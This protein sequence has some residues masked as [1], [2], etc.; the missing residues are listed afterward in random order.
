M[1]IWNIHLNPYKSNS[2]EQ[3]AF[4]QKDTRQL[5][6]NVIPAVNQEIIGLEKNYVIFL[7]NY[8]IKRQP[9]NAAHMEFFCP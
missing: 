2:F 5:S 1:Q 3:H 6:A 4:Q 7:F 9:K 8:P